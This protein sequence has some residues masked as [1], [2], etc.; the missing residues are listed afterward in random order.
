M[1]SFVIGTAGHVDH[2]KTALVRA[3]TGVDTDRLPEEKRRGISIELG[4]AP[5]KLA[6][7]LTAT[8][9]DV[10]GHRRLVHTMIAGASGMELVLLV[11]AA[12]EGVMPQTREHARV[13]EE[14][15][16]REAVVVL[17]K[18]DLVDAETLEMAEAEA[19]DLLQGRFRASVV[20][21]SAVRGTG[22]DTLREEVA[23]RLRSLP[24]WK[25]EGP[26]RLWV[27]RVLSIR[28][29]GT[30]VTGTLSSGELH[31]GD[32][33]SLL[34]SGGVAHAV[35]R[36][37]RVRE[38]VVKKA[39]SPT[40]L[41]V[42]MPI[43]ARAAHKGDLLTNDRTLQLTTRFDV[44]LRGGRLKRG[45]LV[46]IHV[47][48]AHAPAHVTRVEPLEED[49]QLARLVLEAGRPLRGGDR[50]VVRGHGGA[51]DMSVA[52]G[53]TVIDAMPPPRSRGEQRR[54]LV[55]ALRALDA[56]ASLAALLREHAPQPLVIASLAGRLSLDPA[57]LS[58]A[59]AAGIAAG[60]LVEIGSGVLARP[61]LVELADLARKLVADHAAAAPLDRGL[62]VATLQQ[63]LARRA[64]E[65]AAVA[66]IRS[67]R[68]RR[69]A[70]D[71]DLIAV[72]NDVAVPAH[73]ARPLDPMVAS[74]VER[75][76]AALGGAG[77]HGVSLG[78]M[79]ELT[80]APQD[81]V[82]AI[83]AVLERQGTG[84]RAGDLWFARAV[85]DQ[86]RAQLI[87]HFGSRPSVT[88]LEFKA[89][90]DLPRRQA[91]LLLEYFDQA[92][93][94]RRKGDARVLQQPAEGER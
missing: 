69:S 43:G 66:A 62:P 11:V 81:R 16:I 94:T 54:E 91:V 25:T 33:V 92:G 3:L 76:R 1:R 89:L 71:A 35:V 70:D 40:R 21:C 60:H 20:A 50:F 59:L 15:G 90:G 36:Q 47:G 32:E 72:E 53:G 44:E 8:V 88:V 10:P 93:L 45:A 51:T 79:A 42:N 22:L 75:A 57:S 39:Q 82:R 56:P 73:R 37:L 19:R 77:V 55:R 86:A 14:L 52:C 6:E 27:D 41:A 2:G 46:S 67:A 28:G 26:A 12:N 80:G 7:D 65:E 83:L 63:K 31:E 87:A 58:R 4:F 29:A 61:V 30:V 13:C 85:V 48:S 78:K 68:A 38:A 24:T 84:V 34:G 49:R 64:G 5:W 18:A 9:V 74:A 23:A 17:T